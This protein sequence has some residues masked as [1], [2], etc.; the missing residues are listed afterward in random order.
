MS[1]M[2]PATAASSRPSRSRPDSCRLASA[3]AVVGGRALG[4]GWASRSRRGRRPS[5]WPSSSSRSATATTWSS[6]ARPGRGS[7]SR[8]GS[9]CCRSSAGWG[10]RAGCRTRSR[11][12][13]PSPSS[14]ARR[15]P[16][17]TPGPM[18][19]ATAAAGV[20]SVATRLGLE[21]SW[22]VNA[23]LLAVVVGL[24]IGDVGGSRRAAG[25]P[26]RCRWRGHRGRAR[27]G[28]RPSRRQRPTRT[29]LGARSGRGRL[30]A[31]AWLAGT[32]LGQ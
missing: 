24:A 5:G 20:V 23:A 30:L 1:W 11:S 27:R 17:P 8:S 13:S 26:A 25:R 19:S 6:R 4:W 16:S 21:R 31:A 7:R 22:A 9:R 15:W 28:P 32:T 18:P 14:P 10:P 29:S 12:C 3:W 2:H